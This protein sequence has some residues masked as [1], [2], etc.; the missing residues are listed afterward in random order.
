M[1]C[2]HLG[3]QRWWARNE[4]ELSE[5]RI[6]D[7][8]N[9]YKSLALFDDCFISSYLYSL[10]SI[11][12]PFNPAPGYQW[13]NSNY[14]W[15]RSSGKI[16]YASLLASKMQI[17]YISEVLHFFLKIYERWKCL[18]AR[19]APEWNDRMWV[20]TNTA[21]TPAPRRRALLS[22]VNCLVQRGNIYCS[23]WRAF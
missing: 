16:S 12:G 19:P 15:M 13:W 8:M 10:I 11:V 23:L 9:E 4:D 14:A 1:N 5:K 22:N 21:V 18:E 20:G 6:K 2:S 17:L 7:C 3:Y